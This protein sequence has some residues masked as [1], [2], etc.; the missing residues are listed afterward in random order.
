MAAA[1]TEVVVQH[2]DDRLDR[3]LAETGLL[4]SRAVATRLV[5]QG[6]VLVNG[7]PS[8]ASRSVSAG[9]RVSLT[10]PDPEPALVSAEDIALSVVYEDDDM[11]VVDK[12]A[13]MVVHPG[14]GRRTG[15]LVNALLARHSGWPSM[16]GP[17][18]PGIVH[19]LD[20]GTSGL[21]LVARTEVALRRLG[22]DLAGRRVHREYRA[23]AVGQLKDTGV[24]EAPIGRNPKERRRMAVVDEGRA[25]VTHFTALEGLGRYTLLSVRLETGRTHQVRVHLAAIGHP[26]LG[27]STYGHPAPGLIERPAL[28]S[29]RI[30]FDHP[31]SGRHLAFTAALP[32]DIEAALR[33][34]RART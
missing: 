12:P 32:E 6:A 23:V 20:K 30:E 19:R 26:L 10:I 24:I 16:G 1:P 3:F 5:R 9:D 27:D 31:V 17:E 2:D 29:H 21:M 13:G 18:R 8:R 34:L 15:T 25:A 14:A 22:A 4:P 33:L 28:H 11:M 7:L